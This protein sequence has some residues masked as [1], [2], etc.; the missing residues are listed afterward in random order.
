M[1][2]GRV[3]GEVAWRLG[4]GAGVCLVPR[5]GEEGDSGLEEVQSGGDGR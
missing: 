5:E 4:P 2:S 3:P 1:G